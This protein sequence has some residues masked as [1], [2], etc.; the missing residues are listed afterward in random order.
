[1]TAICVEDESL[2]L[3][4]TVSLCQ[5]LPALDEVQGFQKAQDA[6]QWLETHTAQIALLDIDMPDMDGLTLASEIKRICPMTNIIIVTAY[7]NFALDALRLYVSGFN[8]LTWAKEIKWCDPEVSGNFLS[9]PQQRV[10]NL[11]ARIQF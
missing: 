8:L 7:P 1:M 3:Q 6:L 5:E 11:G 10:I 2:I 4:L 9:Y